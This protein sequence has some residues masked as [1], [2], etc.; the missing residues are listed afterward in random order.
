MARAPF[1]HSDN[2][3]IPGFPSRICTNCDLE[4]NLATAFWRDKN[5]MSYCWQCIVCKS[6]LM[7]ASK[8]RTI[9]GIVS[10]RVLHVGGV[11]QPKIVFISNF[12][13]EQAKA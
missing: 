10:S 3:P 4:M 2:D 6:G 7:L 1:D 9:T 13:A 5:T 11:I 8:F 12:H